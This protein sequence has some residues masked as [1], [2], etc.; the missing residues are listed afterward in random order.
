MPLSQGR[1]AMR[2]LDFLE[3]PRTHLLPLPLWEREQVGWNRCVFDT[4]HKAVH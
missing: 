1:I 3:A 2:N 4:I